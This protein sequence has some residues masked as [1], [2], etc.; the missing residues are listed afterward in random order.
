M[1]AEAPLVAP[2]F[3]AAMWC[4]EANRRVGTK[5]LVESVFGE[6]EHDNSLGKHVVR[7]GS[8]LRETKV[9]FG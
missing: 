2:F 4:G 9:V 5:L 8:E 1:S 3:F 6:D 7:R